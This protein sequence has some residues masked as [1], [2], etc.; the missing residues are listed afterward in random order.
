MKLDV[1]S[2]FTFESNVTT[3]IFAS[4]AFFATTANASGSRAAIPNA[5][6][7]LLIAFSTIPTCLPISVSFSGPIKFTS[8]PNSSPAFLAPASTDLQNS[9][10]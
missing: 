5:D 4:I 3:G 8:T 1:I 6:T 2:S 7:F 9:C 10:W